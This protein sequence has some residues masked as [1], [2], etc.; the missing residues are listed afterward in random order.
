MDPEELGT[1]LGVWDPRHTEENG[2]GVL[3]PLQSTMHLQRTTDHIC[4]SPLATNTTLMKQSEGGLQ[5][6]N[7]CIILHLHKEF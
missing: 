2:R 1:C 4:R 6:T 3:R 5:I 7:D